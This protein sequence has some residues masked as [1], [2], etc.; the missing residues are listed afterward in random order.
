[1]D[2][3][4]RIHGLSMDYPRIIHGLCMDYLWI[5]H[6]LSMDYPWTSKL[7]VCQVWDALPNPGIPK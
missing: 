5:I 6:A 3:P 4:W 2:Y 7:A 1:M